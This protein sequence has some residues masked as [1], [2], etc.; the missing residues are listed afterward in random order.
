MSLNSED[1]RVSENLLVSYISDDVC[2]VSNDE[3]VT[4]ILFAK[5]CDLNGMCS[6]VCFDLFTQPKYLWLM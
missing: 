2:I 3:A 4:L 6:Y 5:L 1:A